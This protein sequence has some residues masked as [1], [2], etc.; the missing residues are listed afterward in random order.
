MATLSVCMIVRDEAE[1]LP[2]FLTATQGLYDELCV[3]DTGSSDATRHLLRDAGAKV[4][5]SPWSDDF[6]QARN[7]S[8]SLA[9]CDFI[10]VLDA[11]EM[12]TPGFVNEVRQHIA[13]PNLGAATIRLRSP[14]A[15]GHLHETDILRLFRRNF[16]ATY[17][18]RIHEEIA[19]KVQAAIDAQGLDVVKVTSPVTHLGYTHEMCEA[20]DKKAR[21]TKLLWACVADDPQDIYSWY[22]LLEQ[23]RFHK[24]QELIERA[25]AGAT[26]A[27]RHVTDTY[28]LKHFLPDLVV[29]LA[30]HKGTQDPEG[31]HRLLNEWTEIFQN[32]ASLKHARGQLRERL[33]LVDSAANDFESC[34]QLDGTA[35]NRQLTGVR[36]R[37]GLARLALAR[38]DFIAAQQHIDAS[39]AV[40]PEDPEALL[41]KDFLQRLGSSPRTWAP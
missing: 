8:L 22:K 16:G 1:F 19:S 35:A 15:Y 41:A 20:R 7:A 29:L 30:E 18:Y 31:A 21:D 23:G 26:T 6:S 24:D 28:A 12:I 11:D 3:A 36:P 38:A 13:Q 40:A 39:L 14:L 25:A 10:L 9:T 33:G 27:L 4:V 2:Q 5:S 17:T 32:S 37:L 34:L